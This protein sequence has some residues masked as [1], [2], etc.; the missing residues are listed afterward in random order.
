IMQTRA[1]LPTLPACA[2]LMA[3]A[4]ALTVLL[5]R[6]PASRMSHLP[7][8]RI[9]LCMICAASIGFNWAAFCAHQRLQDRLQPEWEGRDITVIGAVADLPVSDIRGT[10]FLFAVERAIAQNGV[11]PIVPAQLSLSWYA[12]R[13]GNV[14]P[15][16]APGARWQFTVRLTRPHGNANPD[17]YDYELRL[18]ERGI[19]ATGYIRIGAATP[20]YLLDAFVRSPSHLLQR[21]RAY[22]KRKILTALPPD[23]AAHAGVIV[24]LVIGEQRA[25]AKTDWEIFRRTGVNHL[26]AISGLHIMMVA[27]LFGR[28]TLALWRR[29]CW[30]PERFAM[31]LPL[32]LPAQKAA[33]AVAILA[34]FGYVA[35]AGFGIPAQRALTMLLMI[36]IALW[37]GRISSPSHILCVALA[38]VLLLDPWALLGAGFHLSFAAVAIILYAGIGRTRQ[39]AQKQDDSTERLPLR[40]RRFLR[41]L[42]D[43]TRT[44]WAV[45]L[46]LL[47]LTILLF[48]QYSL[49]GPF[50]NALAIPVVTLLV[51]P[52]ALLGVVLPVPL[53]GWLLNA[54]HDTFSLI[55]DWLGWLSKLPVAVWQ[56]PLPGWILFLIALTGTMLLLAPR[57]WPLRWAGWF[58][59]LPLL[60][61]TPSHPLDGELWVSAFDIGQGMALLVETSQHRLLYDTGPSYGPDNDAGARIILPYLHAR[62]IGSLNA[63]I[64][65]HSDN[66]HA[67]GALSIL[68]AL[69][70]ATVYSSLPA[71]HRIIAAAREH[72]RC[73]SGQHWEWDGIA[74]EILH[75]AA[76]R[77]SGDAADSIGAKISPNASSCVLKI[78]AGEQSILLPGDIGAAQEKAM[79]DEFGAGRLQAT[80]LLAPHHGSKTSSSGV[81]LRA[82]DPALAIF[83]VGYR[84][85]FHHPQAAVYRRYGELGI[86]RLRTDETGAITLQFGATVRY[87]AY[88]QQHARYWYLKTD[89]KQQE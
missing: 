16:I 62:G 54:A 31:P 13:N 65:S 22:L 88:R 46:G 42:A 38:A 44:Q 67:G 9:A 4:L 6:L 59:W 64:V 57:G 78:T 19:G 27:G 41:A 36:S 50:A 24:A 82:V 10:R 49:I 7:R 56:A 53:A 85:R 71:G 2:V 86:E 51:V 35:L 43:G 1:V 34:A 29:S 79:I 84:N 47:P 14:V 48:A 77:Y 32:R 39:H 37:Q 55:F 72:R 70:V 21:A 28:L 20:A 15:Q 17:G 89:M 58:G 68:H 18:L 87:Q 12:G 60:L 23:D 69:P 45:S 73:I 76:A 25:I 81:F 30:L 63:V 33:M 80:V 5:I 83:Q 40:C 75:P 26:V 61:N 52:L 11:M 3:I 74:F 8:I 66:D